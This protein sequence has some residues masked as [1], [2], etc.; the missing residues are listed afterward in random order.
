MA[1]FD[2][3]FFRRYVALKGIALPH[4][5]RIALI[6]AINLAALV[7]I[8]STESGSFGNG[9]ALLTWGFLN[10]FWLIVLRRPAMAAALSLILVEALIVLSRFK[11]EILKMTASFFDF[12]IVDADTVAFLLT[13]FPDLRMT[14]MVATFLAVPVLILIWRFDPFRVRLLASM[15][16]S[17]VCLA[18]IVGLASAV[19]EEP[20]EPFQGNNH[21]SNFARSGVLSVFELMTHGFLESDSAVA[22]RLKLLPD[23]TCQPAARPPHIII[24]LDES[25]FDITA[26]PGIKVPPGYERH[27]RSFDGKARSFLVE[28]SGGPTWYAEYNVL[29]GLS[30]RSFGR[31]KFNVTRIA[32]GRV[33]RGLPQALRRCGY[34]TFSLYPFY[35][36]FLGARMFQTTTGIEHFIDLREMGVKSDLQPD[37]FFYDQALRLIE[38]E[39]GGPPLFIFVYVAVNHFPWNWTFRADLTPD[40]K[41]LG[42]EPQ[43]DEYIRRQTMSA[44]DYADFLTHL[45]RDFLKDSFL[46]LRFGDHQPAISARILNPSLDDAAVKQRF[47]LYDPRYFSTYYAIDTINFKPVD[48]SSALDTLDAPYLPLVIQEAAGL[49]L[50]PTFVEQKKILERCKGSFYSCAAGAEAR[51]FNRLL[52]DAGLIKGL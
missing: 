11:F 49:P 3:R 10:F 7:R 38:R 24:L 45:R 29:T 31:F 22:D 14:V 5:A 23:A 9:V 20:W 32:A 34:K 17:A 28:A 33:E 25:S 19:P 39:R 40:W 8:Y 48:L 27:F 50:D 21:I 6:A 52:I 41:E 12:L 37:H 4:W 35:G 15:A 13:V 36:T 44:R 18:G 16:G 30:A 46:L 26:A 1:I 51:R 47:M 2:S 43:V 42:N